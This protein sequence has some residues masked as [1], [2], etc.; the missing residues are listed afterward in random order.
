MKPSSA[1]CVQYLDFSE[2]Y[3]TYM[4]AKEDAL[5]MPALDLLMVSNHNG[6]IE[7]FLITESS[8]YAI[9]EVLANCVLLE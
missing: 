6:E 8:I 3:I 7:I 2:F 4:F 9:L 5:F 1:C